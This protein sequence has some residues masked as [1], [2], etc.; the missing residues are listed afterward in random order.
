VSA[1]ARA[2]VDTAALR[3]NLLSVREAAPGSR[4]MAVIKANAYGHGLVE[5]ARAL[6]DAD[7]FA[8]ARLDEAVALRDA[9][10]AHRIVLLEGVLRSE[11]LSRAAALRLEPVIH[12]PEQVSA[13]EQASLDNP[14]RAWLK[15]DTGM[16]RLGFPPGEAVGVAR[17]LMASG[18]LAKPPVCMTHLACADEPE[19][20]VTRSQLA[21]FAGAVADLPGDRSAANSAAILA[22]PE[23]HMDWVRPG[24]MLYGVSP[25]EGRCGADLGLRPVMSLSSPLIAVKDVPA[26]GRVGYGGT[27]TADRATRIGIAAVGYGDGY[28]RCLGSTDTPVL[29]GGRKA[30]LVGRVSM[31]MI[32]IDLTDAGD[33][34]VGDEVTLWG[35]DL[36]VEIL[37]SRAGTIGYELLCGVTQRVAVSYV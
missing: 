26:G 32:A 16:H 7:A 8:V 24:I 22:Y 23:S 4:V 15:I 34:A 31:D 28:P 33:A 37:A 3:H 6:A 25:F 12:C 18:A 20:T 11:E 35:A 17:R 13:L 36:P 5:V 9:G 27:W 29:L 1:A 19:E 2:V 30:Q 10:L 14:L 21:A